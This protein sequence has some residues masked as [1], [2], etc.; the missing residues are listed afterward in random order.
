[1]WCCVKGAI[2]VRR[3]P[4]IKIPTVNSFLQ[5]G[6]RRNPCTNSQPATETLLT[7]SLSAT[8]WPIYAPALPIPERHQQ[9][10]STQTTHWNVTQF[11]SWSWLYV[12]LH[13]PLDPFTG[14]TYLVPGTTTLARKHHRKTGSKRR[15]PGKK[16][17]TRRIYNTQL[18][19]SSSSSCFFAQRSVCVWSRHQHYNA[20][21]ERREVSRRY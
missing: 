6:I 10:V 11:T 4:S 1:M 17:L 21:G 15:N 18:Y 19:R 13:F 7:P 5:I 9:P 14:S 8:A 12:Y 16:F 20:I 2:E 3:P